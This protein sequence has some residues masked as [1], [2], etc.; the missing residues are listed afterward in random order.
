MPSVLQKPMA[1]S[2]CFCAIFL[3]FFLSRAFS[4]DP[5]A[6]G[7]LLPQF[8]LRPPDSKEERSYL[9]ITGN[10]PF[11]IDQISA[12]I[13]M[14][15]II[16][17]YC[18][19]C[20]VQAPS[21]RKLYYRIKKDSELSKRVKMLAIAVGATPME[22]AYLKKASRIPY[23]VLRDPK[24]KVHKLLGNPRTPFTFLVNKKGKILFEHLGVIGDID[25][26]L[27]QI[28]KFAK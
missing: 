19:H 5:P 17:V 28:K 16:G 23:P 11:S 15:E 27:V 13:I 14:V 9:G 26:F 1:M 2:V 6:A 7:T 21:F 10:D 8:R 22:V 12:K 25:K 20:H 3:S 24:F 4:K 18:P